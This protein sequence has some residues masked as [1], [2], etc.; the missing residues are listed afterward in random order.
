[1][2]TDWLFQGIIDAEQK[3][4]VL[5]NYFQKLNQNLEEIKMSMD[6]IKEYVKTLGFSSG[7]GEWEKDDRKTYQILIQK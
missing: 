6:R 7:S 3:E 1:M 5:L 4:Y 2:D